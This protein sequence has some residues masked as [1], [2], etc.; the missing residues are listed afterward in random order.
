[1]AVVIN[2]NTCMKLFSLRKLRV[3]F[4]YMLEVC[5]LQPGKHKDRIAVKPERKRS[6]ASSYEIEFSKESGA[7]S[8]KVLE[9]GREMAGM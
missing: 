4:P 1:M 5:D 9:I 6:E 3:R 8:R 7:R 2:V